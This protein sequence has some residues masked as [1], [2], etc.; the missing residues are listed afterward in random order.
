VHG[1]A[2]MLLF[3]VALVFI[4]TLDRVLGAVLPERWAQ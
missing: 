2:G 1:F 3:A 4:M